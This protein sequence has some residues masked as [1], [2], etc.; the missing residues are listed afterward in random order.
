M[1]CNLSLYL[2]SLNIFVANGLPFD[3]DHDLFEGVEGMIMEEFMKYFVE[4]NT[5]ALTF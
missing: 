4:K 1:V 5:S 2:I 3:V